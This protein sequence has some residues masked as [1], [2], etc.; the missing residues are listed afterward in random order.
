M[1]RITVRAFSVS[2]DGF[3]AGPGQNRENPLGVGGMAL[4]EWM[5]STRTVR[6]MM[7]Q[8]GGT[9][10]I[11]DGFA[12]RGF[13]NVGAWVIGRNMFG[14]VRGPWPDESW[15]GWWGEN[16][17]F[18]V[19]VFV[20]THHARRA[21]EMEGGTTFYF[22]TEGI[23]A[24]ASRAREAAQGKEVR[25]GGGVATIRQF[26]QARMIEEMHVAV[27]PVVMGSGEALYAGLNLAGL[28][29][30]CREQVA[31]E[32]AVHVLFGREG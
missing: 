7:G 5:F 6:R 8:E 13:E 20:L 22:V 30:R 21:I 15:R 3:G 27:S 25:L 31:G 14:P 26:L 24:A 11:D 17:P 23:E 29:Y 28:G 4:H 19:P 16:P 32:K 12:V 1:S 2:V 10:G 9:T 18:Q